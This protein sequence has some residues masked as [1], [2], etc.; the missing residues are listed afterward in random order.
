MSLF[1]CLSK[2][3]F[4]L[5]GFMYVDDYDLFQCGTDPQEVI[6]SM[7]SVIS[8]W[9]SLVKVV[10]GAM[11]ASDKTWWYLIEFVWK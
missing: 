2:Q 6:V 3:L 10:G 1:Y 11:D 4:A 8:S 5:M 9:G 7:Q